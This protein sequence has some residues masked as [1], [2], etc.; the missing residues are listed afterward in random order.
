MSFIEDFQKFSFL[1]SDREKKLYHSMLCDHYSYNSILTKFAKNMFCYGRVG[2]GEE[3]TPTH[4]L[5]RWDPAYFDKNWI[6]KHFLFLFF[7]Q[8]CRCNISSALSRYCLNY[9]LHSVMFLVETTKTIKFVTIRTECFYFFCSHILLLLA[10]VV[11][12]SRSSQH[13]VFGYR[14]RSLL[15]L[16][17]CGRRVSASFDLLTVV[18][19]PVS[20]SRMVHQGVKSVQVFHEIVSWWYRCCHS[21]PCKSTRH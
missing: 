10:P 19:G 15:F 4:T 3:E 1:C 12:F 9:L 6:E 11:W 13:N 14:D 8:E 2:V 20:D 21:F 17:A 16:R 7:G 5:T 18:S